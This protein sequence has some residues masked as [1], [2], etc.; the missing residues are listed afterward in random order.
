MIQ[1]ELIQFAETVDAPFSLL[2]I[3]AAVEREIYV[4]NVA[5]LSFVTASFSALKAQGR[6]IESLQQLTVEDVFHEVTNASLRKSIQ[7]V[8]QRQQVVETIVKTT[9]FEGKTES[10]LRIIFVKNNF[11]QALIAIKHSNSISSEEDTLVDIITNI[12]NVVFQAHLDNAGQLVFD[13]VN[14]E[15]STLLGI[16]AEHLVKDSQRFVHLI[17]PGDHATFFET[18]QIAAQQHTVWNWTGSIQ[19]KGGL[20]SRL[21]NLRATT[22]QGDDGVTQ[23][24]GVIASISSTH[25]EQKALDEMTSRF[26][27]IVANIPSLVF[28]CHL[29]DHSQL[30]FDY[31]SDG[32]QALIGMPSEALKTHPEKLF[33]IIIP[34]DRASFLL[35]MQESAR[36][37]EVWNWE[38]GLWIEAWNDIKLVNLRA[39]ATLNKLGIVQW[40]GVITNITQSKKAKQELDELTSRFQAIV[41]NIPSLVF[42]GVYTRNHEL[43]FSYLSDG[44]Q[45]VLGINGDELMKDPSKLV[46]VILPTDRPSFLESMR[47]S[48]EELIIW[49]WEGG[50]WIEEWQDVKLINLRASTRINQDGLVQWGGV[51]TNIT[52]SRKAK[53]EIEESHKQLEELSSHMSLI[54]E[55]ERL[56][57]AREIHDDL[58]GNLTAIKIGLS[59]LIGAIDIKDSKLIKKA[60][61]LEALVDTT[62]NDAHRIT[63]DLRPNIL[64]LGIV[65]ALR[66]QAEEF[67]KQIGIPCY[68]HTNDENLILNADQEIVLFRIC[69][70]ATVNI[71]KHAKAH[72]VEIELNCEGNEVILRIIDDGV[73]ITN[74]NKIKKNA[75]GLR[76]MQERVMS[77]GGN[78]QIEPDASQ[79]TAIK[80]T[81]P[82]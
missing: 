62:F 17:L 58:G 4:I 46:D 30:S 22:R 18:M 64:E 11:K 19:T 23:W 78:I 37:M 80:A 59:S 25:D 7:E 70:E 66:W 61:M 71:A 36:K 63:S 33:E 21:I 24:N 15:S 73:G 26:E 51:I 28:Q 42:Q 56:R 49:N 5:S 79:G 3:L 52:Q 48:A 6:D 12:P 53:Q 74:A 10:H 72:S 20:D 41:S 47:I 77:V 9:Q 40:G 14:R 81:I 45:A 44:C 38:G 68:F 39:T 2:A 29:N 55:Q 1:N 16:S 60:K 32:C 82:L 43:A 67:E 13:F 57:I 75:F 35:T 27:A 50:L 54:K 34:K 65:A 31:L 76:G 69:Q 8:G